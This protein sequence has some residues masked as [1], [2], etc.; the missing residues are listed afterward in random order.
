MLPCEREVALHLVDMLSEYVAKMV[1][2][3][4]YLRRRCSDNDLFGHLNHWCCR[5]VTGTTGT[6]QSMLQLTFGPCS[7]PAGSVQW[8]LSE[9]L[10]AALPDWMTVPDD[11]VVRQLPAAQL[12]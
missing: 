9:L 11:M 7:K 4:Q 3:V 6:H 8:G 12:V 2:R 10:D 1:W 5:G